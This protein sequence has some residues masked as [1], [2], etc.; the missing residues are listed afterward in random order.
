[1]YIIKQKTLFPSYIIT[2]NH[3]LVTGS[4]NHIYCVFKMV[5]YILHMKKP[6]V[7]N[8]IAH[9]M[10]ETKVV[11]SISNLLYR[12]KFINYNIYGQINIIIQ[13]PYWRN[14]LF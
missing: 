12:S 2:P 13:Q 9:F 3:Y 8:I 5:L 4:E 11:Q 6:D 14:F 1:M 10:K 7:K